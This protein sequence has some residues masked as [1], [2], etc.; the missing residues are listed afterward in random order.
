MHSAHMLDATPSSTA[1]LVVVTTARYRSP[2]ALATT[3][4]RPRFFAFAPPSNRAAGEPQRR[5]AT[6]ISGFRTR[7]RVCAVGSVAESTIPVHTTR[8]G[9]KSAPPLCQAPLHAT[10]RSVSACAVLSLPLH[11]RAPCSKN[12]L[13]NT[14]TAITYPNVVKLPRLGAT[15]MLPRSVPSAINGRIYEKQNTTR[16]WRDVETK[17]ILAFSAHHLSSHAVFACPHF[18]RRRQ[19][20]IA[21]RSLCCASAFLAPFRR[22]RAQ[23]A[24]LSHA[25]LVA[26]DSSMLTVSMRCF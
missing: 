26:C 12:A 10:P 13:T 4:T 17:L 23:L 1:P 3:A 19:P 14:C 18:L 21:P 22:R 8:R 16:D 11:T 20:P 25:S 2:R 5:A 6:T 24:L 9:A 7:R 15:K